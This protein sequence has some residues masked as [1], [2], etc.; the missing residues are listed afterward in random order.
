V[1]EDI[2]RVSGNSIGE[3]RDNS[4]VVPCIRSL[5]ERSIDRQRGVRKSRGRVRT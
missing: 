2:K 1:R 4:N 3:V 5:I